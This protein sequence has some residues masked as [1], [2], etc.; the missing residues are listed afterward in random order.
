[1]NVLQILENT[2]HVHLLLNHVPTIGF[3]IGLVLFLTGLAVKSDVLR[4]TSLVMFFLVAVVAI[5]TYVSG[6]AAEAVLAG[7]GRPD[8][9]PG[10]SP[11][12]IR[13]HEDAA[14]VAFAL[15]EVTG[16]F[17]WLALW[18]WRRV[19]RLPGWNLPLVFVLSLTTFGLMA[20]AAELG[21]HITHPE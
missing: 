14:L 20:R 15:M 19:A 4:R 8:F 18:Q 3:G 9:P 11:A 13:A 2:A 10:V 1:M 16:F 17:A 5:A 7:T 6:N 21:G 12:A